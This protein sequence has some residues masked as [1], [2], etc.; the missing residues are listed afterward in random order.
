MGDSDWSTAVSTLD[1]TMV[2]Q[3]AIVQQ[4]FWIPSFSFDSIGNFIGE[5]IAYSTHDRGADYV[6]VCMIAIVVILAITISKLWRASNM[7]FNQSIVL[8]MMLVVLPPLM[9]ALLSLPP[10]EADVRHK[11][12][13]IFDGRVQLV[14][15]CGRRSARCFK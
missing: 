15:R 10:L 3:V 12:C 8:L 7:K 13:Y 6:A 14:D 1:F 2:R 5:T 4:G 9:L 11:I